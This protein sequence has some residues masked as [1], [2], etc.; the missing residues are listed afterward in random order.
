MGRVIAPALA[1]RPA[2]KAPRRGDESGVEDRQ[3]QHGERREDREADVRGAARG[4]QERGRR[5]EIAEDEAPRVSHE[6]TSGRE[7]VHEESERC[8]GGRAGDDAGRRILGHRA[9]AE[10][11]AGDR[12]D[13]A[14][15]S[16]HVVDQ[17]HGV[18]E[19]DDP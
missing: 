7:V 19:A 16:V 13:A 2:D 6:D 17:V 3:R 1:D 4:V 15:Q 18:H 5:E 8:A 14:G 9:D 12:H 10:G 11:D